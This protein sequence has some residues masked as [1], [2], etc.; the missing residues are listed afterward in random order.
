M[1]DRVRFKVAATVTVLFLL[2]ISGAGL[3]VRHDRPPASPAA[4]S[5]RV[6]IPVPQLDD[7]PWEDLLEWEDD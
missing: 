4:A 5:P 3:V 1:S 2:G 6:T 7:A